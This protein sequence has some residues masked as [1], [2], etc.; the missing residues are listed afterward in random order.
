MILFEQKKKNTRQGVP[1][2]II[3][4]PVSFIASIDDAVVITGTTEV[5]LYAENTN[6]FFLS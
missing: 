4:E 2:G 5:I 6:I 1:Y 3:F